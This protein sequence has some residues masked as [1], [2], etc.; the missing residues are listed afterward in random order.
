MQIKKC[1]NFVDISKTLFFPGSWGRALCQETSSSSFAKWESSIL[2]TKGFER[3]LQNQQHCFSGEN[4]LI[5]KC[6]QY[7]LTEFIMNGFL[8]LF[9][10][11]SALGSA[12]R[13]YREKGSI[14]S[15]PPTVDG[16]YELL[17]HPVLK[18]MAQKKST[19]WGNKNSKKKIHWHSKELP[20]NENSNLCSTLL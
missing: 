4:L 9:K 12:D 1:F 19:G 5:F 18:A 15:G 6:S 14:V 17:K 13:P 2:A 8:A 11:Y 3:F 10:A 7:F 16:G 20:Q